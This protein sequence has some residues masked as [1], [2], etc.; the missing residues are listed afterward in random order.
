MDDLVLS[1]ILCLTNQS[2]FCVA[3]RCVARPNKP[4]AAPTVTKENRGT[5]RS[6]LL[7][8]IISRA[9]E[10]NIFGEYVLCS[11]WSKT[12]TWRKKSRSI[13]I[14]FFGTS[15]FLRTNITA[16]SKLLCCLII[17]LIYLFSIILYFYCIYFPFLLFLFRQC[18]NHF[19]F[20][21]FNR[22]KLYI[23]IF[24]YI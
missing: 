3:L 20:L 9:G 16:Y 11:H 13:E 17:Y 7:L 24:N 8:T 5:V 15:S 1:S 21:F 2:E 18:F 12:I 14:L 10:E 19:I 22:K 4:Q 6:L 23:H